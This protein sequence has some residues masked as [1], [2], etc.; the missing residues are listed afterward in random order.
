MKIRIQTPLGEIELYSRRLP[1]GR[2]VWSQMPKPSNQVRSEKQQS[3]T[4]RFREATRY[5]RSAA[6]TM[7]IYT[8]LAAK[9][10]RTSAYSLAIADWFHPPEILDVD[11][12]YWTSELG[13]LI[14]IYVVDD[15]QV[16]S[17]HVAITDLNDIAL[18]QGPATL[19][20]YDW[21]VYQTMV[22]AVTHARVVVTA[23]DLPGHVTK[24][25]KYLK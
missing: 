21:W 15:V 1:D 24:V 9:S 18:E 16:K 23:E 14:G 22:C 17:V 2:T 25:V 4:T 19:E 8:D 12:I 3:Q 5:A 11:V 20:N 7:R 13:A 10:W 6:R